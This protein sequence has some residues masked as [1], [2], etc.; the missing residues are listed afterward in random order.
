[1]LAIEPRIMLG[2]QHFITD[3]HHYPQTKLKRTEISHHDESWGVQDP[4]DGKF[5]VHPR[6]VSPQMHFLLNTG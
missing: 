6:A 4:G 5:T 1:M 2:R 3:S